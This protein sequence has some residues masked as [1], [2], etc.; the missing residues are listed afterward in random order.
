MTCGFR[1]ARECACLPGSCRVQPAP[2]PL[3]QPSKR[4]T[5]EVVAFWVVMALIA[6]GTLQALQSG[7]HQYQT[8]R[9]R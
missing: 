5:L 4:F 9:R 6:G 1:D 3:F 2:V 8:D 7:E